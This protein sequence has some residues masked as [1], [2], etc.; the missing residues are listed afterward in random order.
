MYFFITQTQVDSVC[1]HTEV[2]LFDLGSKDNGSYSVCS[3]V[4]LQSQR[5]LKASYDAAVAKMDE[6]LAQL[7][8]EKQKNLELADQLQLS[9][10]AN[11]RAQQVGRSFHNVNI[12]MGL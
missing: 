9:D 3:N 2:G 10:L 7:K 4:D 5:T 1:S 6:Q 12:A 11:I 8:K